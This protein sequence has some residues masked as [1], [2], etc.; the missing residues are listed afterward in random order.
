MVRDVRLYHLFDGVYSINQRSCVCLM[1]TA[2]FHILR[3]GLAVTFLWIGILIFREPEA[4]GGLLQPWAAELILGSLKTAMI[5]TALLDIAIGI[6]LLINVF[7]WLAALL[8]ALHLVIVLATTGITA[9]TVRDIGLLAAAVA[10]V[11]SAWPD[12]FGFGGREDK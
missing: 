7:T 4:W 12:R 11:V 2:S 8:G 5:G 6:F 3:V 9:V 10:L 1:K